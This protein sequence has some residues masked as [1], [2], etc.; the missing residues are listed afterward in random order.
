MPDHPRRPQL[1]IAARPYDDEEVSALVAEV[2]AEYVRRYGSPDESPVDAEQ[3]TPPRGVFLLASCDGVASAMGGW[4]WVDDVA[5]EIKR[6]Y[7]RPEARHRGLARRLLHELELRAAAAGA[8]RVVLGTGM[9]Q[10][11]AIALYES[12]GYA[13]VAGFGRYAD[14][15]DARF[16]G[17]ALPRNCSKVIRP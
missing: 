16:Y 14:A 5:V 10:P 2:Q 12:S 7:V 9:A 1:R 6:M 4:R 13:P 17:K 11:E 8:T 15:A 3:F